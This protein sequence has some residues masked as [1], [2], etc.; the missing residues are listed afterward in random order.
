[1][2]EWKQV[3]AMNEYFALMVD[4]KG[5][6][7]MSDE[8]RYIV[9]KKLSDAIGIVNGIHKADI[10]KSMTFSSGDSVQGLFKSIQAAYNTWFLIGNYLFPY[11][12]W[13]GI[14][15]G[16][17]NERLIQQLSVDNS[18]LY[19]GTA[20][21]RARHAIGV[22]KKHHYKVYVNSESG[23]DAPINVLLNDDA[24]SD[25]TQTRR[26]IYAMTNIIEPLIFDP[27]NLDGSHDA[28]ISK[29]LKEIAESYHNISRVVRKK[30]HGE[31]TTS[32]RVD[33]N[34]SGFDV[35]K[36]IGM[37]GPRKNGETMGS[38]RI[39][40]DNGSSIS[41]TTRDAIA[42]LTQSSYQNVSSIMKESNLDGLRKKHI[43]SIIVL[44]HFY[45]GDSL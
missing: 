34:Q 6:T 25:M 26:A 32:H 23:K 38:S 21:H 45:G 15:V 22:A 9:Q 43:A 35:S 44:N 39:L 14:G 5:S 11:V 42:H 33:D 10:I 24:F 16:S 40:Y 3:I 13:G 37:T 29:L 31:N 36:M 8:N 27:M 30:Q 19:D 28:T 12:I 18:N 41:S 20:Y 17:V 4:L 7:T 2:L 1:M